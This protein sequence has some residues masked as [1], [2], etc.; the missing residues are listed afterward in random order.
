MQPRLNLLNVPIRNSQ[1]ILTDRDLL[2]PLLQTLSRKSLHIRT[3]TSV[4]ESIQS[5]TMFASVFTKMLAVL[6]LVVSLA[7]G[8]TI[9]VDPGVI[10][11]ISGLSYNEWQLEVNPTIVGSEWWVNELIFFED[12]A[13]TAPFTG[14]GVNIGSNDAI[15]NNTPK[16][17]AF[18]NEGKTIWQGAITVTSNGSE[19]ALGKDW[20]KES[21]DYLNQVRCIQLIQESSNTITT[22]Y[23]QIEVRA[24]NSG[25][26]TW[27]YLYSITGVEASGEFN[28]S[29]VWPP[30]SSSPTK[31]PTR[32]PSPS[33]T[34]SP[35]SSPSSNPTST[36][37][38]KPSSTPTVHPTVSPT[39]SP[40]ASPS[41]SPSAPEER[42]F[43]IQSSF[44]FDD[45]VRN[46]CLQAVNPRR[47]SRLNVRPCDETRE[48]KKQYWFLDSLNQL[49][50]RNEASLC[51]QWKGKH[52]RIGNCDDKGSTSAKSQVVYKDNS[53][54]V[55]KTNGDLYV[56]VKVLDK[57]GNARL[58]VESRMADNESLV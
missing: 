58:F 36:P 3:Y 43:Q 13:C 45:S 19:V 42:T 26:T 49:R 32:R 22:Q 2:E 18:D 28:L 12:A 25:A 50:L 9:T 41:S 10:S 5:I 37:S 6:S 7:N 21:S 38:L 8:V 15:P 52:L 44:Y 55:S 39:V 14:G 27:T 20:T 4:K 23:S 54:V 47:G 29:D 16:S 24:R 34:S 46:W 57:Y 1:T 51:L 48:R 35:T 33:P 30:P 11:T 31:N 53:L 40:S 17:N 56:G